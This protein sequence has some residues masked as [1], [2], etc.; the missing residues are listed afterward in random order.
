M[1]ILHTVEFYEPSHG[2]MQEVVKQISERLVHKGHS[3]TVATSKHSAR[4]FSILN[5]VT[6]KEFNISGNL[7]SGYLGDIAAYQHFLLNSDFDIIV[8]FAA[9]QWATDLMLPL[10][11]QIRAKKVSVPTGFSGLQSPRYR[12]YFEDMKNWMRQYDMNVFHS[13]TYQDIRFARENW[14]ENIS[15]IP[16]ASSREEFEE[17]HDFDVKQILNIPKDQFLIILV[18]S[19]DGRKGHAEAIEIFKR[20][21]IQNATLVITGSIFSRR[22]YWLCKFK[23]VLSRFNNERKTLIVKSLPR[24]Q[25]VELYKAADLFLFPTT[26]ECSPLVLFEAMAAKTPFLV[27]DVGNSQEIIDWTLGGLLLPTRKDKTG[28]SHPEIKSSAEL[29]EDIVNDKNRR[30]EMQENGY[31]AWRNRFTWE[32]IA[33]QYEQMYLNLLKKES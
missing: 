4:T 32:K 10:L 16:N 30:A 18:G 23:E 2:G 8:N 27:T 15:V 13:T 1:K 5:G 7:V 31:H 3:V 29:L 22:C 20:A 19:H 11:P 17:I 26:W 21:R 12:Q 25:I 28:L 9:Q 24:P 14:I 6:I 33:E